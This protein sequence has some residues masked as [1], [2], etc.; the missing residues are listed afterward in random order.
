M[1]TRDPEWKQPGINIC[2]NT[3]SDELWVIIINPDYYNDPRLYQMLVYVVFIKMPQNSLNSLGLFWSFA[4]CV[5]FINHITAT[6]YLSPLCCFLSQC[7]HY[8]LLSNSPSSPLALPTHSSWPH[9]DP[10]GHCG[11]G[12]CSLVMVKVLG[13]E[14]AKKECV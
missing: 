7:S 9:L 11:F 14:G 12:P 1:K 5:A 2:F 10:K 4:H 13:C 6:N 8:P 3:S